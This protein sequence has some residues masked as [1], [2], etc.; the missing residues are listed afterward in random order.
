MVSLYAVRD[1]NPRIGK[2]KVITNEIVFKGI[3]VISVNVVVNS[4]SLVVNS[5]DGIIA[6][7]VGDMVTVILVIHVKLFPIAII[8]IEVISTVDY[9]EIVMSISVVRVAIMV[10]NERDEHLKIRLLVLVNVLVL[11]VMAIDKD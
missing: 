6:V 5:M 9:A 11:V 10:N 2:G 4:L 8:A 7:G 3:L 1:I